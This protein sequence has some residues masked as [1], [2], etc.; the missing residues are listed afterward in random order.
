MNYKKK[1]VI[2]NKKKKRLMSND[3]EVLVVSK[4]TFNELFLFNCNV[5]I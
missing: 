2:I 4:S 3:K 1:D 5:I